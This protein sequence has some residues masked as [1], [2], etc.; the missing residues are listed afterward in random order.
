MTKLI[1]HRGAVLN[2]EYDDIMTHKRHAILCD[3]KDL[4]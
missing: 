4:Q 2:W 1:T 3:N